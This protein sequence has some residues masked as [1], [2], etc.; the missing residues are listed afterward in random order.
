MNLLSISG[1]KED[2]N[3]TPAIA[4]FSKEAE[5]CLMTEKTARRLGFGSVLIVKG[6]IKDAIGQYRQ[7]MAPN[8]LIA[9]ISG[10][11]FPLNLLDQ[12]AAVCPPDIRVIITGCQ[13]SVA[14]YRALLAC[15][16]DDYLV[17][18]VPETVLA[19]SLS[20]IL[21]KSVPNSQGAMGK[22]IGVMG[23]AGGTGCTSVT[24]NLIAMLSG[25]AHRRVTGL[26]LTGHGG[27]ALL[28]GK[29]DAGE[30]THLLGRDDPLDDLILSRSV[31]KI[32]PRA[33]LLGL[34]EALVTY[35]KLQN[36]KILKSGLATQSHFVVMDFGAPASEIDLAEFG[37]CDLSYLVVTAGLQ[38]VKR[39]K[40]VLQAVE[41]TGI[42]LPKLIL[43]SP[44]TATSGELTRKEIEQLLNQDISYQ[45]SHLPKSYAA[46]EREGNPVISRSKRVAADYRQLAQDLT[47]QVQGQP[48]KSFISTVWR[49][50]VRPKIT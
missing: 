14:L 5:L 19:A 26:D 33:D 29:M 45:F 23:S 18:P 39:A 12:L 2:H 20:N 21:G 15:G 32:G 25:Q 35:P 3:K 31:Q 46:S 13:D 49:G 6:D 10:H 27:L 48:P 22:T 28:F 24:A 43:N 36:L 17:S 41:K 1:L 7:E 30:L 40:W 44:R 38:S 9:D 50:H 42:P 11:E 37:N 16:V 8:L 4:I 34:G 47:G